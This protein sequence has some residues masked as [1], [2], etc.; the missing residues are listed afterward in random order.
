[1]VCTLVYLVWR[2][3][4]TMPDGAARWLGV[5]FL[6]LELHGFLALVLFVIT[7]WDVEPTR[8]RLR[9]AP[10]TGPQPRVTVLVATYDERLERLLPTVAA[11]L[12]MHGDHETWILDDGDRP[13]VAEMA[14]AL[15]ARYVTRPVHDHAKAGDLNSALRLVTTELIAVFDADHVPEPD[16]LTRTVPYFADERLALVQT[17][18]DFYNTASFEHHHPGSS[19]HE[20][21]LFYRVIQAGKHT[22]GAAF[23]CG[24]NAVLRVSALREVGGVA[25][26]TLTED[27]HTTMRLHRAGWRTAYHNEVLASGLAAGTPAAFYAQRRRWGPVPCRCCAPTT[28]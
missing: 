11:V 21:S 1:M 18:Q 13:E 26:E 14:A 9:T 24:T 7:T 4:W 3:G 15:G 17:P 5:P 2:I 20:E 25:T 27:F 28:P 8:E 12:A 19:L 22:A 23:W 10:I 16:F 6:V